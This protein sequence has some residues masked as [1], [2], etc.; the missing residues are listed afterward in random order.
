MSLLVVGSVALDSVR[1]PYGSIREGLGGSATYFSVAAGMFRPVRLVAVVGE[2]FPARHVRFLSS[3]GVDIRGLERTAGRTFRWAGEYRGDMNQAATLRTELN[4]FAS[5]RP[6]IPGA[7]RKSRDVFLAN[8]D[9]DLQ[10]EVLDQ[11]ESP[12]LVGCDTMNYW[13]ASKRTAVKKLLRRVHLLLVNEA[14]ARQL[15]EED[16]LIKAAR[17]LLRLGP[18]AVVVKR[19]EYGALLFQEGRT[20]WVPAYPL[21]RVRDPTGAG[22]SFAGGFM[23]Y[24]S[25][26]KEAGER[27]IRRALA[28]GSVLASF[29]VEDFSLRRL[30]QVG[31][32][33]LMGRYRSFRELTRF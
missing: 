29:C 31:R 3:R 1:T 24:L 20:C 4:V 32:K 12:R 9:P 15:A 13:I 16:N 25:R 18:R 2:D 17:S 27:E 7:Y 10:I 28:F 33:D 23:G 5:F 26:C 30:G 6:K 22:D 11:M 8:I 19:G 14:E 21:E